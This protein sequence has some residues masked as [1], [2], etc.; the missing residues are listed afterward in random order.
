MNIIV[1]FLVIWYWRKY[2]CLSIRFSCRLPDYWNLA[3]MN[4]P[5]IGR[6]VIQKYLAPSNCACWLTERRIISLV[7]SLLSNFP[8]RSITSHSFRQRCSFPFFPAKTVLPLF[9]PAKSALSHLAILGDEAWRPALP[10]Q[11]NLKFQ[12]WLV[13]GDPVF[14]HLWINSEWLRLGGNTPR[15]LFWLFHNFW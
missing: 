2:Y 13:A 12:A 15:A 3:G 14:A 4:N 10:A 1:K 6:P 5:F 9:F 11:K 8:I 7:K